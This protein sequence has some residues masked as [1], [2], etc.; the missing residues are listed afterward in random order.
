MAQESNGRD[1]SEVLQALP[2]PAAV[3]DTDYRFV[4]MNLASATDPLLARSRTG[5][6][7]LGCCPDEPAMLAQARERHRHYEQCLQRL[8]PLLFKEES[9]AADGRRQ[10]FWTCVP[11]GTGKKMRLIVVGIPAGHVVGE[12]EPE[13]VSHLLHQINREMRAPLTALVGLAGTLAQELSGEQ[14]ARASLIDQSGRLLL[15]Q[16]NHLMEKAEPS[17][18]SLASPSSI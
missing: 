11:V 8:E 9:P 17:S 15:K 16:L 13:A 5:E 3:L 6:T 12:A 7:D 14:R 18:R 10:V 4:L 1:W 2:F